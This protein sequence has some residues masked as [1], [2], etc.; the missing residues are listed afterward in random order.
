MTR[1]AS[2]QRQSR[3]SN[4]LNASPTS[5]AAGVSTGLAPT[6]KQG[7]G[8]S[9]RQSAIYDS[10]WLS[11]PTAA[12]S[13]TLAL[14]FRGPRSYHRR[15]DV[16]GLPATW[17]GSQLGGRWREWRARGGKE[18]LPLVRGLRGLVPEP[19]RPRFLLEEAIEGRSGTSSRLARSAGPN[20]IGVS[21]PP[22]LD[23][24]S[25]PFRSEP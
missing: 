19:L 1:R 12:I 21:S 13:C 18:D 6:S 7:G 24:S 23:P 14:T 8:P 5:T 17:G 25:H 3:F 11:G 15:G 9:P 16:N 22:T 2:A 10:L 20:G 4:D